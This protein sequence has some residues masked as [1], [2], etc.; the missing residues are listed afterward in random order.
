M[1]SRVL[2]KWENP[3]SS[4]DIDGTKI[5]RVE[6]SPQHFEEADF[7][8]ADFSVSFFVSAELIETLAPFDAAVNTYIDEDEKAPGDY[9]YGVFSYNSVGLGPG[10]ISQHTVV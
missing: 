9:K 3:L 8:S 5:F 7:V 6:D 4:S 2:L 1:S 10:S